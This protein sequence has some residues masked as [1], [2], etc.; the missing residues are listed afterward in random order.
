MDIFGLTKSKIRAQLLRL[1]FGE[2]GRAFYVRELERLTGT[3]AGNVRRE[4][5]RLTRAGLLIRHAVGQTVSYRL[6][7]DY[8]LLEET[9]T[10]VRK[11]LIERASE[12]KTAGEDLLG[13]EQILRDALSRVNGVALA[14]ASAGRAGTS[15]DHIEIT[16]VGVPDSLELSRVLCAIEGHVRGRLG[17]SVYSPAEYLRRLSSDTSAPDTVHTTMLVDLASSDASTH[18]EPRGTT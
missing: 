18:R 16:V 1:F 17:C 7:P 4:L 5:L 11:I 8:P 9:S 14:F 2:E 12:T 13:I 3:S 10:I 6:N 15:R